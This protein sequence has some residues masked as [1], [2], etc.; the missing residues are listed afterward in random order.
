MQRKLL[1]SIGL[2]LVVSATVFGQPVIRQENGVLNASSY[3][4]D[5]A[6]GSW[7]VIFGTGLGP[8][9]IVVHS[10]GTPYPTTLAGTSVTFTPAGGGAAI[11]TRIWYTLATQ[12][13]GL[14]PSSAPAGDYDVRVVYNSQTSAARR[15]RVVERNFGF[16]TQ[17]QNGQGPAQATYGGLD[18][19]RFTTGTV[20]QYSVRPARAGDVVVLWGTG[21]GPDPASDLTGG[22]SGDQTAAAQVRVILGG[23]EVT[24]AYAG[25]SSGSPGLDQINFVVPANVSPNCFVNVQVRAGAR[26]SNVG[27]IAVVAPGQNACSHPTLSQA[28][29]QRLDQGGTL[30]IGSLGLIKMTTRM[31][32]PGQ[33]T[34][35]MA[36]EDATAMFARYNAAGVASSEFATFNVG[37]CFVFRRRGTSEEVS[38]GTLPTPLDAGAQL[39][40]NGPNAAN[41][42]MPREATSKTYGLTLYNSGFGGFGGQGTPTI[43][44]G[45]YTIAGTGGPDVGAFSAGLDVPG[46]FVWANQANIADPIP[47]NNGLNITWTGGTTGLV[48]ITGI[49]M[50]RVGGSTDDPIYDAGIFSC[51]AQASAGSFTVPA[52]VLQQIPAVTNDAS[53]AGTGFISVAAVPDPSQG[54]GTFT[55]PLTGGGNLDQGYFFYSIGSQKMTGWQ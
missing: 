32:L 17:A 49:S 22:T 28:Q 54:Q 47:R 7:F 31:T 13:A 55:A 34:I 51:T 43:V 48:S 33:G 53:G 2:I 44:Q 40:L 11:E 23:V 8:A 26:T 5:I 10:G 46:N 27:S 18:L 6:R 38:A 30:T 19:N 52:S 25:R 14:L 36:S 15:V 20:A 24:P 41:R 12:V 50:A 45:R 35:E 1:M 39:I 29:L 9:N 42:A 3:Q 21:L 4:A 37:S 16:A